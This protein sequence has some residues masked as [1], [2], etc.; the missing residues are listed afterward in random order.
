MKK[1]TIIS[2][3]ALSI[4]VSNAESINQKVVYE[5]QIKQ[6]I[7]EIEN[8]E[9]KNNEDYY[10]LENK[11]SV[12]AENSIGAIELLSQDRNWS[13]KD[14]DKATSTLLLANSDRTW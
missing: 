7:Q 14:Q 3:A 10:S 1:I 11:C 5:T 8:I 12:V 6:I 13:Y 9:I 4:F 2:A